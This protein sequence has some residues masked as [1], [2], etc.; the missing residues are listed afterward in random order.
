MTSTGQH[1]A[2]L[3][4]CMDDWGGSEELWARAIPYLKGHRFTLYK[5]RINFSHPEIK[6][7]IEQQVRCVELDPAGNRIKKLSDKVYRKIF[8]KERSPFYTNSPHALQF[9]ERLKKDRPSF[10]IIAQGINFDGL[11]YAYQ[12]LQL[13]IPYCIIAQ[14]AVEF[15]WP[16]TAE[17]QL[18][19]DTFQ[20]AKKCYF[21]SHQNKT[22]TEEQFGF[23][24]QN[25]EV[26]WN[27]VKISRQPVPYPSLKDGIFKLAF[28]G[29]L[30]LIDKGQD[31]L[32]R[33]LSK[34]PWASRP[35]SVSF[36]GTG[37]DEAGIKSLTKLLN[38]KNVA[39]QG[40]ENDIANM[41]KKY[42][43]L[44]LSSRSEGMALSVLEAMA[45]GRAVITTNAGGHAEII[46]HGQTGFIG[47]AT[48]NDFARTMEDAW[49]QRENWEQIGLEA[50]RHI[51]QQL[52]ANPEQL[53]AASIQNIL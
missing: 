19:I 24:F 17:R 6:Q 50:N 8:S 18:M 48:E 14:K 21:V 34:E 13:N 26:V 51:R 32:L 28:V 42:H 25:A 7:L 53:F 36:I 11:G 31:I 41:W 46:E 44:I 9:K 10:V 20:Q 15:F 22:L 45:A 40:H 39:F 5:D 4:C 12:C 16:V 52:P 49:H 27:P 1:I 37:H 35:L 38:V 3:T 47:D 43:A 2:I 29:R 23:R 30:F 33:I